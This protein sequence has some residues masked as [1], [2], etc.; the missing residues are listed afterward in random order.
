M[1][2]RGQVEDWFSAREIIVE[3]VLG[4]LGLY[5]FMVHMFTAERPFLPPGLFG[6]RNFVAGTTMTFFTG[7]V[8]LASSALMAPYL[9]TLAGYPVET[10]GLAMA[11]R[12]LGTIVGMQLAS[13]LSR[14]I[15]QRKIMAGGLLTL[16]MALHLMSFWTPDVSTSQ[17]V[18]T[19]IVQGFGIGCVFN[20]MTVMAFTTLPAQFRGYATSMQ[21]LARNL[22][23]AMGVSVTTFALARAWQKSHADIAANIT[24]FDRVLQSNDVASHMLDATTPHGAAVVDEM[25]NRQAQIIAY[26]SDFRLMSLVVVP[27]LLLLLVMR[28]HQRP[29]APAVAAVTAVAAG[30]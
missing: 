21:A 18:M 12:G 6:D 1:L 20:P 3:A 27:P 19:L 28:R 24:P 17:M 23:Q 15:D 22:G 7:T 10:A 25:V 26:N 30:D 14:H 2:D 11:P 8:M 5:L 9:E 4:G 13:S 29:V 16:G